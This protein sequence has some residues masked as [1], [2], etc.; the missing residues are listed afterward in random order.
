MTDDLAKYEALEARLDAELQKAGY[1]GHMRDD[2][3]AARDAITELVGMVRAQEEREWSKE[4]NAAVTD[5]LKRYLALATK[6]RNVTSQNFGA[7]PYHGGAVIRELV[8]M[9]REAR[10]ETRLTEAINR[11]LQ[12]QLIATSNTVDATRCEIAELKRRMR[13]PDLERIDRMSTAFLNENP[14]DLSSQIDAAWIAA[15]KYLLEGK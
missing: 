13:A 5:D 10:K 3:I 8:E 11:K 4:H 7:V 1:A 2:M 15:V 6:L 14:K 12:A 9:V